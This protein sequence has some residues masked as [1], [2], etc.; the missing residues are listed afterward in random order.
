MAFLG[1]P[2]KEL[3]QAGA[4]AMSQGG[5]MAYMP[6]GGYGKAA[7]AAIASGMTFLQA[8]LEKIDAKV[9]EPLTSVT[10]QRDIVAKTGGGWV[11]YTSTYDVDYATSGAN[12][13][14]IVGSST[15]AVPVMQVNM[16]KNLFPTLTW[17]NVL[18]VKFV[19]LQKSKQIGRNL[20]D[21]LNKGIRLNYNKTLYQNVY[22]GFTEYGTTGLLN[23]A[24]VTVTTV[25]LNAGG[26]SRKWEDKTAEEILLDI[27]DMLV[28]GWTASEY[29]LKGMPNHILIPPEQYADIGLRTVTNAADKSILEYLLE[30][31]IGKRQGVNV[32]IE[33]C[34]WCKGAGAGAT[35]RAVAYANDE[36]MLYFDITV[37]N[38]R[39]MT[40]PDLL[41]ASYLTLY[42]AQLGP[43][44]F[45]YY[46]PVG[47]FDGI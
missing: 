38:T 28:A 41:Q 42:A 32:S 4:Y 25:P 18:K 23:D 9:R 3:M 7:D 6:K 16:N 10:W 33:P 21:L 19:D 14:G 27:N 40:Q 17:M 13:H 44:K 43:V 47:Y 46:Q 15:T 2:D 5:H 31:N 20:E 36:D 35:D 45:N 34:R 30:N 1:L 12:Q 26:T 39:A 22:Q 11:E 37:P 24:N 29:D 8:E